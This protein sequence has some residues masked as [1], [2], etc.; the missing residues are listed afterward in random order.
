MPIARRGPV[1][2]IVPPHTASLPA[3][4]GCG[5]LPNRRPPESGPLHEA[6]PMRFYPDSMPRF[7]DEP[8]RD[9]FDIR[10][11]SDGAGE[12]IVALVDFAPG[13]VVFRF[14]GFLMQEQTLFTLQVEPGVYIHDP[15]FMGKT[16]H[17]CDPN[18]DV[19]MRTRTFTARRHIRAGD[20]VTMD[21]DQTED[22]LWRAFDCGCGAASCRGRIAGRLA[23]TPASLVAANGRAYHAPGF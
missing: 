15:Y 13:D 22:M 16:L 19:D 10:P 8:T 1:S 18:C 23:H 17:S 20:L 12:G 6:T 9:R 21:Y 2:R 7:A 14:S 11:I 5:I 4:A 3:F